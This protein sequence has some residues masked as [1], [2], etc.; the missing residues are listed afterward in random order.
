MGFG[1]TEKVV[2]SYFEN[3]DTEKFQFDFIVEDGS[4]PI[5]VQ[6][7]QKF[8]GKIFLVPSCRNTLKH[9]MALYSIMST[10]K[11]AIA[12]CHRNTL[13][14]MPLLAAMLAN[15]P[16]RIS[17]S[18]SAPYCICCAKDGLKYILRF[19]SR[20]FATHFCGCSQ[21]AARWQFGCNCEVLPNAIDLTLFRFSQEKR[22][23]LRKE[24]GLEN[25][26]VLGHI[27]RFVPEKNHDFLL[28]IF[29]EFQKKIPNAK[30]LLIGEG[31]L[32]EKIRK[33]AKKLDLQNA[34]LFLGKRLDVADLYQV[35][36]VFCLPSFYE[37]LPVT[38]VEAQ[39]SGLPCILS[40]SI[41]KEVALTPF[42][43]FCSLNKSASVWADCILSYQGKRYI[44]AESALKKAGYDIQLA[45]KG[46]EKYY[47]E[48]TGR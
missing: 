22:C 25:M 45:A 3:M 13:N 44:N 17:H 40:D 15:I 23:R 18:H 20:M 30:L 1:G 26:F 27:G 46:L 42:T 8:G 5:P 33:K 24:M 19:S 7:I 11:Y 12:H 6:N 10:Q 29:S 36:D 31:A 48:I 21:Q 16:V 34:I 35:M 4:D 2:Q 39:A 28:D 32:M 41:T 47:Q 14:G 43:K 9:I 38:A 37:G